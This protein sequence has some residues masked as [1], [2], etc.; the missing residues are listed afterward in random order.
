MRAT[1]LLAVAAL[2][3][4]SVALAEEIQITTEDQF[5]QV[6][7]Q[8][9]AEQTPSQVIDCERVTERLRVAVRR[10]LM[11][12]PIWLDTEFL[13][14]AI[15]WTWRW[16]LEHQHEWEGEQ[17]LQLAMKITE[18]VG[19][20]AQGKQIR[21]LLGQGQAAGYSPED[22]VELVTALASYITTETP[23][24]DL[25]QRALEGVQHNQ[26]PT[27]LIQAIHE[28]VEEEHGTC[29]HGKQDEG[30][31]QGK[32]DECQNQGKQDECQD[33]GSSSGEA[34][35]NGSNS[36]GEGDQGCPGKGKP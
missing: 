10:Q 19:K 32:P 21:D 2:V 5:V 1:A 15:L 9:C 24:E 34:G 13:E 25:L 29:D 17:A 20:G 23:A 6:M 16:A 26:K 35:G 18:L 27:E 8:I 7:A 31:G 3:L 12:G 4:A 28:W 30:Q 14:E 36:S 11:H 33:N 22:I